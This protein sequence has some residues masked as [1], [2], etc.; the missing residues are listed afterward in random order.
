MPSVVS[1]V[2]ICRSPCLWV[3]HSMPS[4]AGGGP[5]LLP[6][7]PLC[8]L[9][10]RK[11]ARRC[12]RQG[13]GRGVVAVNKKHKPSKEDLVVA[14]FARDIQK[15]LQAVEAAIEDAAASEL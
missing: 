8:I 12:T 15:F 1:P 4:S 6:R 14:V 9:L 2:P 10:C 5:I 7:L 13:Q 11:D 3:Y